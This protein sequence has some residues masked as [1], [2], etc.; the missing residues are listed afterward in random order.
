MAPYSIHPQVGIRTSNEQAVE[1]VLAHPKRFAILG[2]PPLDRPDSQSL[3]AELEKPPWHA[4]PAAL[5]QQAAQPDLADGWHPG[6]ALA[7][8]GEGAVAHGAAR[9]RLAAAG[10]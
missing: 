4:G 1:A 9:R 6:L 8:R 5:L 7:G 10:G 3:I 2:Y